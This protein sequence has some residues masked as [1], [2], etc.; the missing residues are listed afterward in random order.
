MVTETTPAPE[1]I[2]R[3]SPQP[4]LR[5]IQPV[6]KHEAPSEDVAKVIAMH[7]AQR[8]RTRKIIWLAVLGVVLVST[9][10]AL[11]I[12]K[13]NVAYQE[14]GGAKSGG[15]AGKTTPAQ[16]PRL[17]AIQMH[18]SGWEEV[19]EAI[20]PE[21]AGSSVKLVNGRL[22]DGSAGHKTYRAEVEVDGKELIEL[23]TLNLMLLDEDARI[24]ARNSVP[25][26]LLS[27]EH[28]RSS[29]R[30][31]VTV[32]VPQAMADRVSRVESWVQIHTV[33]DA[34][35]GR[36]LDKIVFEPRDSPIG[37]ELNIEATNPLGAAM[38]RAVFFIRAFNRRHETLGRWRI[39]WRHRIPPGQR[40]EFN[41]L[42]NSH[43]IPEI[44]AWEVVAA[45]TV[46]P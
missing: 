6:F 30:H 23:A 28:V 9:A 24:F 2:E 39:D 5:P 34:D 8:G 7:R 29:E 25:L 38:R 20:D 16:V 27:P 21:M 10:V 45:G 32:A 11:L 3:S 41:A 4:T 44:D 37:A 19:D 1:L 18:S 13:S 35:A 42:I 14:D 17:D 31:P 33:V 40:F 43:D 36:M 46:I 22:I 15:D 12:A 26:M